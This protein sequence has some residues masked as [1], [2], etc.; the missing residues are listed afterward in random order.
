MR[1]SAAVDSHHDSAVSLHTVGAPFFWTHVNHPWSLSSQGETAASFGAGR[2]QAECILLLQTFGAGLWGCMRSSSP[3]NNVV[4][5]LVAN[6]C[7]YIILSMSYK[8]ESKNMSSSPAP[9]WDSVCSSLL[10]I[11]SIQRHTGPVCQ[12][13]QAANRQWL[14]TGEICLSQLR[15]RWDASLLVAGLCP[16][17][18]SVQ[19]RLQ[20]NGS[21]PGELLP[22]DNVSALPLLPINPGSGHPD[23]LLLIRAAC[24]ICPMD[25]T[26]SYTG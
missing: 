3:W 6:A 1:L 26:E 2:E 17:L 14:I 5:L 4:H 12:A 24:L 8:L 15:Q 13:I 10:Q 19:D 11:Q 21:A 25:D 22:T 7:C 9:L 20:S 18:I 16:G 23:R